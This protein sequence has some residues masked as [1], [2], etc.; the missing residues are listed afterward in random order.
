MSLHLDDTIAALASPPGGAARGIV[1]V[2][3]PEVRAALDTIFQPDG[4]PRWNS[5][6]AAQRHS[7]R[8]LLPNVRA[9]LDVAVLLWPTRRSYTGEPLAE[10]HLPG[11]PPLLEAVLSALHD[12]GAR[13]AR[14]GEFTLR[15]FLAGRID[16]VQAEAVL[17]VIDAHDHRELETALGQLAGGLSGKIADVR[18][19]LID[20]L[21]D[22]EAGLDFVDEDI[23][24]VARHELAERVDR[25]RGTV[26]RL[27]DQASER[28]RTAGTRCVVLAG[29]PNAGKSTLFNALAGREAA[30]VSPIRG[31][32]RDWLSAELDWQGL[33]IELIDTAGWGPSHRCNA[34]RIGN[35]S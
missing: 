24:F 25:A 9:P 10:L 16:L 15:A 12:R 6:R 27:L 30:L 8:I 21:A 11:S 23:E 22:L 31:T 17:G 34:G 2:S 32:T 29:L 13:P 26:E 3:G 28:M 18:R 35:P 33:A 1:R 19:D 20:L 4:P 5:S 14:P 7:G